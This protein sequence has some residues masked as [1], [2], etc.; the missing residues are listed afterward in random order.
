MV[1]RHTSTGSKGSRKGGKP[2]R[3]ANPAP[4]QT[5][6]PIRV[7]SPGPAAGPSVAANPPPPGGSQPLNPRQH[8]WR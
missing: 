8:F 3:P 4:A 1:T 5:V 2:A 6:P 7:K